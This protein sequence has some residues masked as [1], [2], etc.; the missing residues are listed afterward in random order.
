MSDEELDGTFVRFV[1]PFSL[2]VIGII[3][4]GIMPGTSALS[5]KL[6]STIGF[7][8]FASGSFS[9]VVIYNHARNP[10]ATNKVI[11]AVGQALVVY[12]GLLSAFL[13]QDILGVG[14]VVIASGLVLVFGILISAIVEL[15]NIE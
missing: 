4:L 5:P 9:F 15:L 1:M 7:G 3:T 2:A 6:V 14:S 8:M 11:T 12:G 13:Y 10:L